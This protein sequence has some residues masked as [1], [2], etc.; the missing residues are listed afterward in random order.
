MFIGV[1]MAFGQLSTALWTSLAT[2]GGFALTFALLQPFGFQ[3]HLYNVVAMPLL[4][5]IGIDSTIHLMHAAEY[6]L[7]RGQSWRE[8]SRTTMLYVFAASLTTAMGFFGFLWIDYPGIQ[9][10]AL[11]AVSGTVCI[12]LFSTASVYTWFVV[13]QHRRK[14][15]DSSPV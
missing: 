14:R 10:L 7:Q 6:A 8:V 5:G 15:V 1:W 12:L 3:L 11:L 4:I 2:L 13:Q 9:D